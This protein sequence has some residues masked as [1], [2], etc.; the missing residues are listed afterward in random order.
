MF[1]NLFS[2]QGMACKSSVIVVGSFRDDILHVFNKE[3]GQ[4]ETR[5]A[6]AQIE[7]AILECKLVELHPDGDLVSR[8]RLRND[9]RGKSSFETHFTVKFI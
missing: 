8:F 5:G 3:V 6:V 2:K 9:N 4:C 7:R 1:C